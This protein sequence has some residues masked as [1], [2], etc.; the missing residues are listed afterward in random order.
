MRD[1]WEGGC[2]PLGD[3]EG[4]M[5]CVYMSGLGWRI[6]TQAPEQAAARIHTDGQ[7]AYMTAHECVIMADS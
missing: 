4:C 2:L 6:M 3:W 1:G 5:I 7:E